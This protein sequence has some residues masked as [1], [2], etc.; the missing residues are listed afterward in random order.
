[1][2]PVLVKRQLA[3]NNLV[4]MM[5]L[6]EDEA[7]EEMII[8]HLKK[9]K[10]THVMFDCRK[11]EGT[12]STL[13]QNYLMKDDKLFQRYLRL[14]KEMFFFAINSN[15]MRFKSS[16]HESTQGPYFASTSTMFNFK[17]S[18]QTTSII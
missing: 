13:F 14:P 1:M 4:Q 17:V 15:S 8:S 9:R 5:E 6:E 3:I 10:K 7:H 11:T 12:F 2:L 18:I 16:T